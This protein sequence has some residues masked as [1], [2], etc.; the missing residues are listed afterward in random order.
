MMILLKVN[1]FD[2][3]ENL[4]SFFLFCD[5]LLFLFCLLRVCIIRCGFFLQSICNFDLSKYIW[6]VLGFGFPEGFS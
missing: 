4:I 1:L 2:V 6:I 3:N 5:L